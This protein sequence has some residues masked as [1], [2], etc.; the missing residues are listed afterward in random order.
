VPDVGLCVACVGAALALAAAA[1][2]ASHA[3]PQDRAT[4]LAA[5]RATL[6][7]QRVGAGWAGSTGGC[8]V[9]S[10]S[11]ASLG[12]TLRTLNLLRSFAGVGPIA[13]DDAL[14]H[15]ALAAALMMRAAGALSHSPG[16]DWPCYSDEGA[17]GAG[18]SNLF[19][20]RSGAAAMVGYVDDEGVE[21]LGHRRWLL[22]PEAAVFG[23]GSTGNTNALRVIGG[24]TAPVAPDTAV[25]WPPAGWVPWQWVFSDW[26]LALGAPGQ[27]VAF[28]SPT[29]TVA[30]DGA[31]AEVRGVRS[32][33]DG[34]GSAATLT[35][36]VLVDGRLTEGDHAIG[37]SVQGAVVDGVARPPLAWTTYAFQPVPPAPRFVRGPRIRRPGGARPRRVRPGQRLVASEAVV[38]GVVTRRR[39]LR[40]GTAIGDASGATYR[41]KQRD[42]GH[43]VAV[44]VTAV[45][46]GG[47]PTTVRTSSSVFIAR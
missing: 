32:L 14:N 26:S 28:D 41:V 31:P 23:S 11:P 33:G 42:R 21:S 30:I 15:E 10:E 34:Y 6:D 2:A 35:W 25:A 36:Q 12:A 40:D 24:P 5:Y 13:F 29:V 9:G 39:W 17:A 16:P 4:A 18:S 7:D 38:G 47:E 1:P 3:A 20:G 27:A 8:V 44:R 19:L 43:R 22:D 45:A 37:V 46:P